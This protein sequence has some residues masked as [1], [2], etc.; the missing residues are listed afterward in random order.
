MIGYA[1]CRMTYKPTIA[2]EAEIAPAVKEVADV[3]N[4]ALPAPLASESS[5]NADKQEIAALHKRIMELESQLVK[6]GNEL[7]RNAGHQPEADEAAPTPQPRDNRRG[8][9]FQARMERMK[10]EDP[11]RYKEMQERQQS[12]RTTM[13]AENSVRMT[14]LESLDT[15]RMTAEQK[16]DHERLLDAISYC[17]SAADY[18]GP[19]ASEP[20]TEDENKQFVEYMRSIGPLMEK[21]RRYILE[22]IGRAYGEDGGEFADYIQGIIDTTSMHGPWRGGGFGGRGPRR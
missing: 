7:A 8:E 11:E 12:F 4:M 13:H 22:E 14:Y 2:K 18:M 19:G 21:E 3:P 20:L 10:T 17:D 6:G 16:A 1:V 5:N 9:N 15:S